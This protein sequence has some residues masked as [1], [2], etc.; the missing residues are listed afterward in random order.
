MSHYYLYDINTV[1]V[2]SE[3][4]IEAVRQCRK[5]GISIIMCSREEALVSELIA[6][7]CGILDNG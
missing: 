5:S 7:E 1:S 4:V 3:Q 2:K 6:L